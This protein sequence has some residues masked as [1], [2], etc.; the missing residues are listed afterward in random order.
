M[1]L[2]T[3]NLKVSK[4]GDVLLLRVDKIKG[5]KRYIYKNSR[6]NANWWMSYDSLA[7]FNDG[8]IKLLNV[9]QDFIY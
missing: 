5:I 4:L 1:D 2:L 7:L 3:I 9:L 6:E 8:F